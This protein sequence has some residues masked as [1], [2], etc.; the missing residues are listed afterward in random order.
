ML[1]QH[2]HSWSNVSHH[3]YFANPC[4]SCQGHMI[5]EYL[6]IK[7]SRSRVWSG[8][9]MLPLYIL[10]WRLLVSVQLTSSTGPWADSAAGPAV[11]GCTLPSWISFRSSTWS[12]SE[13]ISGDQTWI[14]FGSDKGSILGTK[15]GGRRCHYCW[16]WYTCDTLPAC[17]VDSHKIVKTPTHAPTHTHT[18]NTHTHTHTHIH[19]CA[20]THKQK[21]LQSFL[22]LIKVKTPQSHFNNVRML[23]LCSWGANIRVPAQPTPLL[24]TTRIPPL[25]YALLKIYEPE[26]TLKVIVS[27]VHIFPHTPIVQEPVQDFSPTGT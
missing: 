11:Y 23:S 4:M 18:H 22:L 27:F 15:L 20:Y 19:A 5:R 9:R 24:N 16:Q 1:T 6:M 7:V 21:F 13:H 10:T 2:R 12:S 14:G 25:P 17:I 8:H 3:F 26:T